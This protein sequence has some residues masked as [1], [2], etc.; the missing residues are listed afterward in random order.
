MYLT[1]ASLL[2]GRRLGASTKVLP[3]LQTS[4]QYSLS[5]RFISSCG[6]SLALKHCFLLA[7]VETA[8]QLVCKNY[9]QWCWLQSSV[10][11]PECSEGQT[12]WQSSS[13]RHSAFLFLSL[14]SQ[15]PNIF[16]HHSSTKFSKS[17]VVSQRKYWFFI[18][19]RLRRFYEAM[20]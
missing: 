9:W 7:Q 11:M 14:N 12:I 10:S 4:S 6:P 8:K 3:V 1:Q 17:C 2:H 13:W 15:Y 20:F 5:V 19:F 18:F 16:T